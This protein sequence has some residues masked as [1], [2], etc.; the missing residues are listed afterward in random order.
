MIFAINGNYFPQHH[1][2]VGVCGG[3]VLGFA[4]RIQFLDELLHQKV[5]ENQT[6]GSQ[7]LIPVFTK[8]RQ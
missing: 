6:Y 8:T 3:D 4:T 7:R 2:P 5:K 1:K